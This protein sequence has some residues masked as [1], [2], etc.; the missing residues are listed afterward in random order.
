MCLCTVSYHRIRACPT[1]PPSG[2]AGSGSQVSVHP[3]REHAAPT[4]C[5]MLSAWMC[6]ARGVGSCT[7]ACACVHV[8][9]CGAT[10]ASRRRKRRSMRHRE[11]Y[12]GRG[13]GRGR[14][15]AWV[16]W[17]SLLPLCPP[18]KEGEGA[19]ATAA[20]AAAPG[21]HGSG[22]MAGHREVPLPVRRSPKAELL[23]LLLRRAP[24]AGCSIRGSMRASAFPAG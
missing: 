24:P 17:T 11:V 23:L 1:S 10:M 9:A 7:G 16:C 19:A 8:G 3:K 5:G 4:A 2:S 20:A 15:S 18:L 14:L 12:P 22:A 13:G 21:Y 6:E